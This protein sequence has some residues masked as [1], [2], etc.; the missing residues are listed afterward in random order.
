MAVY[1]LTRH[2]VH[3]VCVC[4]HAFVLAGERHKGHLYLSYT[5]TPVFCDTGLHALHC[6]MVTTPTQI[7]KILLRWY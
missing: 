7:T 6:C 1:K 4:A 5:G 2:S 3:P